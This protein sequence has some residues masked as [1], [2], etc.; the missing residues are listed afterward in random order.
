MNGYMRARLAAARFTPR[1]PRGAACFWGAVLLSVAGCSEGGGGSAPPPVNTAPTISG[2][3]AVTVEENRTA[4]FAQFTASDADG[5]QL[6][7]F[8]RLQPGR[9]RFSDR[10][11]DRGPQR[12]VSF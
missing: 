11:A 3:S 2:A 10:S 12:A 6:T 5:D 8:H 1:G 9:E 4:S 7:F